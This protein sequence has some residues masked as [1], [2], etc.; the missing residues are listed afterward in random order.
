MAESTEKAD[1]SRQAVD[2][3]RGVAGVADDGKPEAQWITDLRKTFAQSAKP[4]QPVVAEP[5]KPVE[6]EPKP[7]RAA[8][9]ERGAL[10][11]IGDLTPKKKRR[12]HDEVLRD[13]QLRIEERFR[14]KEA[15]RAAKR[16]K[17]NAKLKIYRAAKKKEIAEWKANPVTPPPIAVIVE[18]RQISKKIISN[19]PTLPGETPEM[20]RERLIRFILA[21]EAEKRIQREAAQKELCSRSLEDFVKAAWPIMDPAPLQWS[22]HHSAICEILEATSDGQIQNVLINIAPRH[23]KSTIL[24]VAWPAWEWI[25]NPGQTWFCCSF[26]EN[27]TLRDARACRNLIESPWYRKNW[28]DSVRLAIDTNQVER[29]KT[30]AGGQRVIGTPSGQ[31]MGDGGNRCIIDDPHHSED[32]G[33]KME[34]TWNWYTGTFF[35]RMS[36]PKKGSRV[37]CGQRVALR[38]LFG[39]ILETSGQ[40]YV[41]LVFQE[42]Y[43]PS[44]RCVISTPKFKWDKDPRTEPGE[45]LW[46]ARYD[47]NEIE[48]LKRSTPASQYSARYQQ[49]PTPSGGFQF[50]REWFRYFTE[51]GSADGPHYVLTDNKGNG[52]LVPV[53]ACRRIAV[54]DPACTAKKSGSKPCFTVCGIFDVTPDSDLLLLHLYRKQEESPRIVDDMKFLMGE[55]HLPFL[56]VEKNGIG[57]PTIQFCLRAGVPVRDIAAVLSKKDRAQAAEIWMGNGKVYFLKNAPWLGKLQTEVETFP[58]GEYMDSVDVLAHACG[59]MRNTGKTG[60]GRGSGVISFS[61]QGGA[62]VGVYRAG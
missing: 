30:T 28:G 4:V 26:G 24:S 40:D 6:P 8:P 9:V 39:R 59:L 16:A 57:V 1:D 38:D 32:D 2:G 37:I 21:Q 55:Y 62:A 12:T 22:W 61:G 17:R 50:K 3:G 5:A 20:E 51:V 36:D 10:A 35:N 23:T 29:Y 25:R 47:R 58:M 54:V 27:L 43:D 19:A 53:K 46:P 41:H 49:I 45:P 48:T 31:G 15:K 56:W 7:K 33:A 18:T 34:A 52:T 13:K 42:E 11:P 14:I 44:H 60:S